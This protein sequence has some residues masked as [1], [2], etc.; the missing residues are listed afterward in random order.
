MYA[1]WILYDLF[2]GSI[3]SL[4]VYNYVISADEIATEYET[5]SGNTPCANHD[6]TN[7]ELNFDNTSSSYCKVDLGDF[8]ELAEKWL[9]DGWY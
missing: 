8:A 4:R 9:M 3:D 5:L 6:F 1:R 7:S 2:D